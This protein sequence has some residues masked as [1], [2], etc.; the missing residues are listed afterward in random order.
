MLNTSAKS[1]E[2]LFCNQFLQI[3]T[4]L[5]YNKEKK[6]CFLFC[7]FFFYRTTMKTAVL[8]LLP[9]LREMHKEINSEMITLSSL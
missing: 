5:N 1:A 3:L 9:K 2:G 4:P 7:S 8:I 6:T